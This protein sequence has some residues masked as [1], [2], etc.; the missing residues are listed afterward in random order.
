VHFKFKLHPNQHGFL[1]S[2]STASNLVTYLN[3]VTPSVCSQGQFHSVY[4]DLSQAFDKVP[5]AVLLNKLS[6]FR[7]SSSYVKWFQ[8]YL[9]N[10]SSFVRILGKFSFSFSILSG[11]PQ[12][13]ALGP[14]LFN[15]FVSDLSAIIRHSTFLLFADDLKIYRNVKS[16]EDCKALQADVY[17]VHI[18]VL[19]TTCN[20]TFRKRELYLSRVRQT[21]STLTIMSVMK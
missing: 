18:G 11:V 6:Q 1:N 16:V 5:H 21:V 19:R 4:F 7:L 8:S 14:L 20:L 13:C 9:L 17:S 12:G 10:R 3:D 15:I 2:K